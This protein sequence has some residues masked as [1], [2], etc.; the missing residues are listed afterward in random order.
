VKIINIGELLNHSAA[1]PDQQTME[2]IIEDK[3]KAVKLQAS[4]AILP[5]SISGTKLHLHTQRES[6][7][8]VL[9]GEGKEVIDGIEYPIKANDA[10]FILPNEKHKIVNTGKTELKYIEIFTLPSDFV[11]AE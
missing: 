3:D 8:M 1:K 6:L 2:R 5:P 4:F 9:I 11:V 10:I 7:I